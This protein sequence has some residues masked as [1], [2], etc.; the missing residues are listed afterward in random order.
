MVKYQENGN[1]IV[2]MVEIDLIRVTDQ[3]KKFLEKGIQWLKDNIDEEHR[4]VFIEDKDK[5]K[6]L[7]RTELLVPKTTKDRLNLLIVI[8][9]PAIHSVAERMFFSYERTV[10]RGKWREHRFWRALRDCCML[11][12]P[13]NIEKPSPENIKKINSK[14]QTCLLNGEYKSD[15]NIF[16]LPYFSF[17]TPASGPYSGV[18]G[19]RKIVGEEIFEE[20]KRFEFQRFRD[21]LLCNDIRNVICFQKSDVRK[22]ILA[23]TKPEQIETITVDN[24]SYEVY[25]INNT[26][27]GV[28]LYT[29]PPTRLLHTERGK[30]IL[31]RIVDHVKAQNK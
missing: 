19:I 7:Y 1:G 11:V 31:E 6:F 20:L 25:V 27:G 8:G 22:E 15:F 28:A 16:I 26:L 2:R 17:P 23:R 21:V 3:G 4:D 29:A 18:N 10:A 12:F 30:K 9:N 5:N 24:S 14:K 13:G